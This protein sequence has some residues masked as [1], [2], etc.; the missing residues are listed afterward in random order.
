MFE[1]ISPLVV[2]LAFALGAHR[3]AALFEERVQLAFNAALNE[4]G[5]HVKSYLAA[6]F[7]I[8]ESHFVRAVIQVDNW[9]LANFLFCILVKRVSRLPRV[10]DDNV[11]P[12]LFHHFI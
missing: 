3:H 8:H 7:A 4:E 5:V 1:S 11:D 9:V 6:G 2:E 12:E 10:L